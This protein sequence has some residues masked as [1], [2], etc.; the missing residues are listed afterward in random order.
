MD[1]SNPNTKN[2]HSAQLRAKFR[3]T[4]VWLK[5]ILEIKHSLILLLTD[6]LSLT[7]EWREPFECASVCD[8][9]IDV[10]LLDCR[11]TQNKPN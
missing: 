10:R 7:L 11:P 5:V 9:L 1:F 6:R 2:P 8:R 3:R 4:I